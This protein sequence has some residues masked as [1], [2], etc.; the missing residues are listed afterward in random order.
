MFVFCLVV[1][2]VFVF[3]F[4]CCFIFVVVVCFS[5]VVI[6][7]LFV[8][9]VYFV[10]LFVGGAGCFVCLFLFL[11]RPYSLWFPCLYQRPRIAQ[12]IRL[13]ALPFSSSSS[14]F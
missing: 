13:P 2:V 12:Y 1:V 3:V 5:F 7:C 10:R 14:S 4:C 9:G 6:V 8:L 11:L